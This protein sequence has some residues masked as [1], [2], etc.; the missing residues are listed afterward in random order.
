M[1]NNLIA[2][3]MV[4]VGLIIAAIF[5]RYEIATSGSNQSVVY[6]I[7][8]LTGTIESCQ[9]KIA[10]AFILNDNREDS[11]EDAKQP[12]WCKPSFVG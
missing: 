12:K 1:P 3:A 8:R 7:D 4:A 5:G 2:A 11:N 10:F 9:T 6:R